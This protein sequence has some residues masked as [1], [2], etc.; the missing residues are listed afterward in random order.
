MAYRA[1]VYGVLKIDP[2]KITEIDP[3]EIPE[4]VDADNIV[5]V[6]NYLVS[7]W[8]AI[9]DQ[10][11]KY[12]TDI[13]IDDS[14]LASYL[15]NGEAVSSL[16]EEI[17]GDDFDYQIKEFFN[18]FSPI[19]IMLQATYVGEDDYD[20]EKYI[21]TDENGNKKLLYNQMVYVEPHWKGWEELQRTS[22]RQEYL[23]MTDGHTMYISH[24]NDTHHQYRIE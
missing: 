6:M 23:G 11:Y 8:I 7:D 9:F 3:N 2:S 20:Q 24:N 4:E 12:D 15:M 22:I 16:S 18:K 21:M 1:N 14:D 19:I 17:N 10:S 13:T 5:E